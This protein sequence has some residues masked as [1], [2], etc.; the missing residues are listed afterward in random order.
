MTIERFAKELGVR[1]ESVQEAID[2]KKIRSIQIGKTVL[3]TH[4]EAARLLREAYQKLS[5]QNQDVPPRK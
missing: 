1:V 3:I 2:Q 5:D 4:N